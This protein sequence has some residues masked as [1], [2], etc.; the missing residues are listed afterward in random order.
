[1]RQRHASRGGSRTEV[2]RVVCELWWIELTICDVSA[3][4]VVVICQMHAKE[5][6]PP[7]DDGPRTRIRCG[8]QIR[9]LDA[10]IK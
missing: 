7:L 4:L 8:G 1:M 5:M 2:R 3:S 6:I 10:K 9:Q